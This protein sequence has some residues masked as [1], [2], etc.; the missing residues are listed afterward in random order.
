M[1]IQQVRNGGHDQKD[2]D[3]LGNA[4]GTGGA[5]QIDDLVDDKGHQQNIEDIHHG[6]AREGIP[7]IR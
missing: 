5:D 3:G 6:D 2:H 4:V 1:E 7:D